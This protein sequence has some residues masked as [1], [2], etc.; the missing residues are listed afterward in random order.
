M[1]MNLTLS[2]ISPNWF[3]CSAFHLL[4]LLSLWAPVHKGKHC[5]KICLSPD[6]EGQEETGGG[7]QRMPSIIRPRSYCHQ[8]EGHS[9]SQRKMRKWFRIEKAPLTPGCV[10]F[11]NMGSHEE[12]VLLTCR[13]RPFAKHGASI[14]DLADR[15]K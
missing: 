2:L 4:S 3:L 11:S 14:T 10:K 9:K 6:S 13:L 8:G 12:L 5:Y 1:S 7:G 15:L